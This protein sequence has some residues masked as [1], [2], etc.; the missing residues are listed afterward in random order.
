MR[1]IAVVGAGTM[2][3]GIAHVFAQAGFTVTL[4]DVNPSQLDKALAAITKNMDR[5]VA[6]GIITEEQK[7][8]ALKNITATADL[9]TGVSN[10][11]LIVEAATENVE[12]KLDIFE[13]IDKQKANTPLNSLSSGNSNQEESAYMK[14]AKGIASV[15]LKGIKSSSRDTIS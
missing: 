15:L 1:T 8:T 6:K 2:G 13:E 5:Q 14:K 9:L 11:E 10:A 3:N 7:Q 12:L 4:I